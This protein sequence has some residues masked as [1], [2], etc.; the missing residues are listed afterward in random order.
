L[1]V[2]YIFAF[3]GHQ[4]A[5]WAHVRRGTTTNPCVFVRH[6]GGNDQVDVHV[7]FFGVAGLL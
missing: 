7:L 6:A 4:F 5:C 3:Y 2:Q 1:V